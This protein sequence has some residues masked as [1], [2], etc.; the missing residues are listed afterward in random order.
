[1]KYCVVTGAS[2]GIGRAIAVLF[3]DSMGV[4]AIARSK[5]K[6]VE[7]RS[8]AKNS[9][10]VF[11]V[12]GDV[13]SES[14]RQSI[15][16]QITSTIGR[17]KVDYLVHNAASIGQITRLKGITL[18]D[19]Q[20]TF[21]VNLEAPLFLT[22]SF[23][24]SKGD[25]FAEQAR[26]L[27][28]SSGAAH[29]PYQGWTAYCASKAGMHM[30]YK[31]LNVELKAEGIYVGSL[32]PGVVDS[33]MQDTIREAKPEEFSSLQKF[34]QLK[35]NQVQDDKKCKPH[36]PPKDGLDCPENVAFYTKWLLCDT[37][38][39]EYTAKEWNIRDESNY[40]RWIK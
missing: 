21:A 38:L 32:R 23:L 28:V 20:Q 17:K 1:M 18:K 34:K 15:V 3:S 19:W 25:L 29:S 14:G 5:D 30:L 12:C 31:C 8:L 2:S 24:E 37:S 13:S 7:T 27:H 11:V 40:S 4:L 39:E 35:A 10:N 22:Q 26:V 6:L 9:D 33:K 16:E 36:K